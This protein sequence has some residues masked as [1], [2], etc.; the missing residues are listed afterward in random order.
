MQDDVDDSDE[1]YHDA[2]DK[3][4]ALYE[5]E[6]REKSCEQLMESKYF[7]EI[8]EFFHSRSKNLI[9]ESVRC[10]DFNSNFVQQFSNI[11]VYI[12]IV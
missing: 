1:E 5:E 11:C 4:S 8:P 9:F 2:V 10:K 12:I 6:W 7:K 3:L